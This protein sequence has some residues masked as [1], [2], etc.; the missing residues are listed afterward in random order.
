MENTSGPCCI[1]QCVKQNNSW[2][3]FFHT[4]NVGLCRVVEGNGNSRTGHSSSQCYLYTMHNAG[5]YRVTHCVRTQTRKWNQTARSYFFF[6]FFSGI[7]L[8][9]LF[10]RRSEQFF[11]S[12]LQ[13][14]SFSFIHSLRPLFQ[15]SSQCHLRYNK[16]FI[17]IITYRPFS[18]K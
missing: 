18:F 9:V 17:A 12:W 8:L 13:K 15:Y 1:G 5:E 10:R 11:H 7:Q 4:Q 16:C 14:F 3:I 6:F 2:N